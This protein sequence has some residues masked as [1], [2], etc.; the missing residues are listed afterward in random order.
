MRLLS[1]LI[2]TFILL[3]S[4]CACTQNDGM[5]G[6]WFGVWALD[7]I[8]IN[9]DTD[10]EYIEGSTFFSFH[11]DVVRINNVENGYVKEDRYGMWDCAD[12][13]LTLDFSHHDDQDEQGTSRYAPPEWIHFTKLVTRLYMEEKTSRRMVLQDGDYT[14]FLRKTY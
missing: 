12:G 10:T 13:Y 8:R 6:T 11:A 5:I 3:T 2:Y 9:G 4:M 14:Y 7:E 1:R